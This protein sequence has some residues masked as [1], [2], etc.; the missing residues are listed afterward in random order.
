MLALGAVEDRRVDLLL[1]PADGFADRGLSA[2]DSN[3]PLA[4]VAFLNRGDEHF[5]LH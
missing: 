2:Q 5:E 1:Q 3:S 4:D